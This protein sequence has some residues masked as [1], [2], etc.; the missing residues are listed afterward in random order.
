MPKV[1]QEYFA[2]KKKIILDAA[3]RV[4]LRNPAYSVTMKDIINE[5]NLSQGGVYKY[6]SNIDDIVVSLL[7]AHKINTNPKDIINKYEDDP[8]KTIFE[9]LKSFKN[10]FFLTEK[11]FGK[12][13]FELQ[14]IFFNNKKRFD[15]FKK[16]IDQYITLYFW[17]AELFLFI[18]RKV[19]EKY[20]NPITDTSN[21]YM[22]IIVSVDGIGTELILK[23]YYK[24]DRKLFYYKDKLRKN[25]SLE[26]NLDNLIDTLYKTTLYLLGSK[27][28]TKYSFKTDIEN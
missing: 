21:I 5:S 23:R 28:P 12:I 3:M 8:E 13:M 1:D 24:Y 26:I 6:Y 22:Q 11:V 10:F 16:N 27:E 25:K 9:L 2:N 17:L 14:P 7:N 19:E 15:N 18:D 4:F 20:F